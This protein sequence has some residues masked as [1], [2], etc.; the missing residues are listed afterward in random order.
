MMT[1]HGIRYKVRNNY[2]LMKVK[3]LEKNDPFSW[4]L[5]PIIFERI[6]KFIVKYNCD[7]DPETMVKVVQQHFILDNPLM[8]M[9]AGLDDNSKV[10]G[11]AL[12]CIDELHGKR[13]LTIMHLELDELN[14]LEV[15]R[16]ALAKLKKWGM[17]RGATE[18]QILTSTDSRVRLFTEQ[19]G[20]KE[21]RIQMR[22]PIA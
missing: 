16:E 21:H 17:D 5:A 10:I 7:G 3:F 1:A 22:Q 19:Y 9:L 20:F 12:A 18:A 8:L 2:L 13:W 15:K 4:A 6:K 11:H 14:E